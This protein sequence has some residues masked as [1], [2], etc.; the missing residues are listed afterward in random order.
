MDPTLA[1]RLV[2][3]S[4]RLYAR[5]ARTAPR[6][7]TLDVGCTQQCA[8]GLA[9]AETAGELTARKFRR[10]GGDDVYDRWRFYDAQR[11]RYTYSN[12][13]SAKLVC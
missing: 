1:R 10:G 6:N 11:R 3:H 8:A 4:A 12:L 5:V 9:P 2:D 13:A 7:G